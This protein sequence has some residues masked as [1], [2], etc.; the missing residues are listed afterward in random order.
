MVAFCAYQHAIEDEGSLRYV[1]S[2][3]KATRYRSEESSELLGG[4]CEEAVVYDLG[5]YKGDCPLLGSL[6]ENEE[7]GWTRYSFKSIRGHP[8]FYAELPEPPGFDE[9]V[10]RFEEFSHFIYVCCPASRR[11]H[12]DVSFERIC[13][14]MVCCDV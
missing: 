6:A 12:V 8:F 3:L 9:T 7:L 2:N 10:V 4:A 11:A 13:L 5:S 1:S 14:Q